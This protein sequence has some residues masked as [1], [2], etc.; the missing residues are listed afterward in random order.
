MGGFPTNTLVQWDP[1]EEDPPDGG[2]LPG[3]PGGQGLPGPQ[4]PAGPV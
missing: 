2:G 1:W 4:G 3:P